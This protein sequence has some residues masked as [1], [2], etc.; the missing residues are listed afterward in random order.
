MTSS[1]AVACRRALR[2]IREIA[3]V[4]VLDGS[5]MTEQ[6]ALEMIAAIAGWAADDSRAAPRECSDVLRRVDGLIGETHVESLD[7]QAAFALF[8]KVTGLLHEGFAGADQSPA[9]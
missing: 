5:Q 3:A 6:E 4:T 9:R 8:H 7:D 1:D 2:E